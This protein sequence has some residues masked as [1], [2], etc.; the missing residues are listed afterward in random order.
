VTYRTA[1]VNRIRENAQRRLKPSGLAQPAQIGSLTGT[2][3][4]LA[5]QV[6]AEWLFAWVVSETKPCFSSKLAWLA[7]YQD[8]LLSLIEK[9]L[10]DAWHFSGATRHFCLSDLVYVGA[11]SEFLSLSQL[12]NLPTREPMPNIVKCTCNYDRSIENMSLFA[13]QRCLF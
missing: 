11:N 13:L 8:P 6:A 1:T 2:G 7:G 9:T 3:T 5:L 10:N 12:C 4:G